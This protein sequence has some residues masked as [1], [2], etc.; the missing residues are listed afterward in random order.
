MCVTHAAVRRR[1]NCSGPTGATGLVR[2]PPCQRTSDLSW[3]TRPRSSGLSRTIEPRSNDLSRTIEPRSSG[4]SR[5]TPAAD[6]WSVMDH[7]AEVQWSLTDHIAGVQWSL[8][9]HT[10]E[11][12]WPLRITPAQ[13]PPG[14]TSRRQL[15]PTT[16]D[17]TWVFICTHVAPRHCKVAAHRSCFQI[18]LLTVEISLGTLV[19][20]IHRA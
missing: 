19:P 1:A 6:E 13:W 12:Q 18:K 8:T 11:V 15:T 17:G 2:G 10:A 3:T 14:M 7:A 5:T 9:D 4:L 16:T 20:D